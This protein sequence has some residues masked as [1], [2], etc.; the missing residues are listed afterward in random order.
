[1]AKNL[2]LEEEMA[3]AVA[4]IK[5]G[6]DRL[7]DAAC[8]TADPAPHAAALRAIYNVRAEDDGILAAVSRVIGTISQSL[9][10][11]DDD[12]IDATTENLDEAESYVLSS[13]GERV[14]RALEIL[15]ELIPPCEECGQHRDDVE[16][17]PDPFS[18]S[19][20]PEAT[21][22]RQ[23]PLCPPCAVKRFEDS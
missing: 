14:N 6:L 17:M 23:M 4:I 1:M 21:D 19:L 18:T 8:R 16:V 5:V 10:D 2:T 15:G 3:A 9:T 13:A 12:R 11:I 22:H 20:Y 7:Q